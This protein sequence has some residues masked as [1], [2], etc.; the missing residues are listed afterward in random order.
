VQKDMAETLYEEAIDNMEATVHAL[1]RRVPPPQEV[2]YQDG[3][4]YRYVGKSIHQALVLKLA[5]CASALGA[6]RLLMEHGYVQEQGALQRVLDEAQEDISF[7]AFSVIF[8]DATPHHQK[9]LDAFW[10]EEFDAPTALESTQARPMVSRD[11]VRAYNA[12]HGDPDPSTLGKVTRSI[13]KTYSGYVHGASPHLMDMYLGTP[14]RFY[15]RGMLGTARHAEHRDDLWNC[16][17]RG[18]LAFGFAAKA[19]GDEEL[20]H[21]I[22]DFAVK[23][24]QQAGH[25]DYWPHANNAKT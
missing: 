4:V 19:F 18:I 7:L 15:V 13:S 22:N 17:Y 3:Y 10:E 8:D 12:R 20:F 11:K 24:A 14:P 25:D 6:A 23:F 21:R 5:R 1:S 2:P 9:F 16:F